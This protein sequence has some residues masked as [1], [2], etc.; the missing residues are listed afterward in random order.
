MS[1][2]D[3]LRS[4]LVQAAHREHT[5]A[6]SAQAPRE[7]TASQGAHAWAL[8]ARV[9]RRAHAH[10]PSPA[11]WRRSAHLG[12]AALAS[13]VLGLAGTAVGAVHVGAPLG[14]EQPYSAAPAR[15]APG[16]A[17]EP[18]GEEPSPASTQSAPSA[19]AS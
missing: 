3:E 11:P 12:R 4:E 18:G 13:V 5:A 8:R 10:K 9:A 14:P 6:Q 1:Y 16:V 7:H 15:P 19:P 2:L 17:R